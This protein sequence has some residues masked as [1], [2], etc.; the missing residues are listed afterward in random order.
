MSMASPSLLADGLSSSTDG[1]C[2]AAGTPGLS[3]LFDMDRP[4]GAVV[5]FPVVEVDRPG[6]LEELFGYK[7]VGSL[8]VCC[9]SSAANLTGLSFLSSGGIGIVVK[10][11]ALVA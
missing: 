11:G 10:N 8:K 2:V 4:R 9:H 7:N 5:R 6:C 3:S 1:P